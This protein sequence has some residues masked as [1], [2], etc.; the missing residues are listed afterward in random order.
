MRL[1]QYYSDIWEKIYD[2]EVGETGYNGHKLSPMK[3]KVS[4]R[5]LVHQYVSNFLSSYYEWASKILTKCVC[6][7]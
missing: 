1:A 4:K 6:N 5:N 7:N 2:S 3:K